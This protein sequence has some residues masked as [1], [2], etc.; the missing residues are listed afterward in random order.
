M[1]TNK[2]IRLAGLKVTHARKSILNLLEKSNNSHLSA[3]DISKILLKKNDEVGIATIYRVLNQFV[4]AG[5]CI[6][7]HFDSGQAVFELTPEGHHDHMICVKTGKVIEFE[8]DLIE[9]R[10][11]SLAKKSGYK[12][13]DHSLVLY[14]EPID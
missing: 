10:Q 5:I 6:K 3:D 1:N 4:D 13:V 9:E 8:D 2:E 7:H 12:I 14:V 11:R